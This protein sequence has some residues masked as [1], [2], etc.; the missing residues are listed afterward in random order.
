VDQRFKGY[1]CYEWAL[2]FQNA[3]NLENKNAHF[4][5]KLEM[6]IKPGTERVHAWIKI[7]PVGGGNAI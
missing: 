3:F 4:K 7:E 6:A 1:Y 5:A 2:A